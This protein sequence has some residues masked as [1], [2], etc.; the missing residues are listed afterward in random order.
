MSR[1]IV[2][3][4]DNGDEIQSV[5]D[6]VPVYT[7]EQIALL[8]SQVCKGATDDEFALFIQVARGARLDPFR[9][10]IYGW[11]QKDKEGGDGAKKMVIVV[12]IDGFR[13]IAGRTGLYQGSTAEWCGQDGVWKDVWTSNEYPFAARSI[14]FAKGDALPTV[15]VA[16]WS[17][18]AKM[19]NGQPSGKWAEMPNNMLAK[20]S[21]ALALRKRFPDELSGIY[22]PEEIDRQ[23]GQ[24][25]R[26][27]VA[28]KQA[29]NWAEV[30]KAM[31]ET[32]TRLG[33]P[34]EDRKTLLSEWGARIEKPKLEATTLEERSDFLNELE[35][36]YGKP[37]NGPPPIGLETKQQIDESKLFG[38]LGADIVRKR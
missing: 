18:Y 1:A 15:A 38:Q 29:T 37:D 35:A 14:V 20:C 11:K 32:M 10:Q 28:G 2:P 3:V 13:T 16:H 21:E 27:Q 5:R 34:I 24:P 23:T 30:R 6:S 33:I 36:K 8:K 4:G 9:K 12:G 19:W 31:A 26:P 17:E 22:S 7:P 25:A